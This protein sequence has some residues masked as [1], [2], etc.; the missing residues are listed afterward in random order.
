MIQT[1]GRRVWATYKFTV[2]QYLLSQ[3]SVEDV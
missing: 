3:V 1:Q 2:D